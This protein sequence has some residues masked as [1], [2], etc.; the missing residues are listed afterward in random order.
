MSRV[1]D[2]RD[3]NCVRERLVSDES[4]LEL[5]FGVRVRV[6]VLGQIGCC[7]LDLGCRPKAKW[8]INIP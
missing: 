4:G 7:L 1:R 2:E 5:G 6:L 8:V 3:E